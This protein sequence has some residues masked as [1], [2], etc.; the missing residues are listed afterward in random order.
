MTDCQ[1]LS[2]VEPSKANQHRQYSTS[3]NR[4]EQ[5]LAMNNPFENSTNLFDHL[6]P[7]RSCS[8]KILYSFVFF[9]LC[10]QI[11]NVRSEILKGIKRNFQG[12]E[13]FNAK[14]QGMYCFVKEKW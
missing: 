6:P 12:A 5:V 7:S 11:E 1:R 10:T 2:E 14:S 9:P 8:V 4:L 13:I 3:S